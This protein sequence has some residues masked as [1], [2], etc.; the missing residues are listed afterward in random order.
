MSSIL[1]VEVTGKQADRLNCLLTSIVNYYEDFPESP[2]LA[3]QLLV[4]AWSTMNRGL[5]YDAFHV[6]CNG[7]FYCPLSHEE[8]NARVAASP[9]RTLMPEPEDHVL[10]VDEEFIRQCAQNMI[11]S[12]RVLERRNCNR[13]QRH[14]FAP[15]AQC[16]YEIQ[17]TDPAWLH[18]LEPGT[19]WDTTAYP[20]E[21]VP[22]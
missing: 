4:E 17:V 3:A 13:P 1:Y 16:D 6:H 20:Y 12:I 11:Q 5:L 7:G 22:W 9:I 21:P 8:I 2:T 19:C 14:R 10:I 15:L 18:H